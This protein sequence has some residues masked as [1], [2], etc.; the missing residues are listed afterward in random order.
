MLRTSLCL[1]LRTQC[2]RSATSSGLS[3]TGKRSS[4][5]TRAMRSPMPNLPKV[6]LKKNRKAETTAFIV[7]GEAPPFARWSW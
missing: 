5:R 7:A 6:T 1:K 3:T 2:S 4:P